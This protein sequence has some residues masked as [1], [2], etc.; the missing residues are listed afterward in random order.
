MG[1]LFYTRQNSCKCHICKHNIVACQGNTSNLRS[2]L[3]RYHRKE[4]DEI[5]KK[6]DS[7]ANV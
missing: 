4:Y 7:S 5:Q 1:S 2:Y 6:V 3:K